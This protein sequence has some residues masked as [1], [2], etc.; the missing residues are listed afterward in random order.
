[1]ISKGLFRLREGFFGAFPQL[2]GR[3]TIPF[4]E[5][6]GKVVP[7]FETHGPGYGK[8]GLV[9]VLY[10]DMGLSEPFM[11]LILKGCHAEKWKRRT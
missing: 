2:G 3:I 9:R 6:P 4:F 8:D 5:F 7:L 1:M 10:Q 11:F